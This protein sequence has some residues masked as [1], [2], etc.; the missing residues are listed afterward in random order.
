MLH[1]ISP[2]NVVA[3]S[4]LLQLLHGVSHYHQ[5]GAFF[6][7]HV[8]LSVPKKEENVPAAASLFIIPLLV[9]HHSPRSRFLHFA[10]LIPAKECLDIAIVFCFLCQYSV[11]MNIENIYVTC[12][13][14]KPICT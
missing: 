3:Y 4:K 12:L 6:S 14:F 13:M 8:I 1:L 11:I 7:G 5:V 9:V 10:V 2:V